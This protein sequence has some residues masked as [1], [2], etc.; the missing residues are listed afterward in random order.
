MKNTY[1]IIMREYCVVEEDGEI[2]P[3][4]MDHI[5][6]ESENLNTIR[7]EFQK[8]INGEHEFCEFLKARQTDDID[9]EFAISR[10]SPIVPFRSIIE[11]DDDFDEGEVYEEDEVYEE[12]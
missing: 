11:E 3:E 8:I 10:I 12:N 2:F 4:T 6:F 1:A 5:I 9:F 7:A